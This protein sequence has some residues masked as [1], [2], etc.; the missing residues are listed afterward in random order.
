[1]DAISVDVKSADQAVRRAIRE[2]CEAFEA[3][4]R[5]LQ[6]LSPRFWAALIDLRTAADGLDPLP[7]PLLLAEIR[8]VHRTL[9]APG[10][11][12]YGTREGKALRALYGAFAAA[13]LA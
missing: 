13:A 2:C 12:G 8:R 11:F 3:A 9:G 4:R 6:D 1:M 10:D 7:L 5:D